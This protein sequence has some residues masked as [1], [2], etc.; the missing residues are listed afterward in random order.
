MRNLFDKIVSNGLPP[1][2]SFVYDEIWTLT[3]QIRNLLKAVMHEEFMLM[4]DF[5]AWRFAPGQSGWAP[6]RDKL[7]GS[8]YPDRRPKSL[9][10]WIPISKAYP[11]NS[12]M[13][14]LPADR[15][16]YYGVDNVQEFSA[17]PPDVRALPGEPGDVFVWTQHLLH[18]GSHSADKHNLGPR[19]SIAFE[20]QRGD[21]SAFNWPLLDPAKIP[22]FDERLALI[23]KQIMQ[24]RHMY[25]FDSGLVSIAEQISRRYKMP[26]PIL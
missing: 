23:S 21:V 25:G 16:E 24:Y 20:C 26:E 11:L 2:F 7:A 10:V 4:P 8:L 15:D 14:V 12:C 18:W 17:P 9:T 6:H 13:Y 1:V 19:M 22:S 5:W 3:A